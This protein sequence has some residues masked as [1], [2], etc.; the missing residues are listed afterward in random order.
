MPINVSNLPNQQRFKF[1]DYQGAPQWF[2]NFL[3]SLN[4]FTDPTYQILNGNVGYQNLA[5]PKLFTKTVTVDS[6]GSVAFNFVNPLKMN[7]SAVLLGNVYASGNPSL[8]STSAVVV[9]WHESQ[10]SIYIDNITGLTAATSYV[11]TLAVF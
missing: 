9:F 5:V 2:A 3:Q 8:H 1:E 10:G 11:V 6:T 7:A 4:L